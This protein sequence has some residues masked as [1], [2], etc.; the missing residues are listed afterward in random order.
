M[1]AAAAVTAVAAATGAA[2]AVAPAVLVHK[3][4]RRGGYPEQQNLPKRVLTRARATELREQHLLELATAQARRQGCV[5]Q[6][7]A[8]D[9][10]CV[11]GCVE[12]IQG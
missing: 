6:Q 10:R 1:T 5:I 2:A 7:I 11:L 9:G 4:K 3:K 8:R 12:A